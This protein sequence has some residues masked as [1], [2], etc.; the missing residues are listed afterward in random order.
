LKKEGGRPF[1]KKRR[2]F[3]VTETFQKGPSWRLMLEIVHCEPG[4]P[5]CVA[6]TMEAKILKEDLACNRGRV[7]G[8]SPSEKDISNQKKSRRSS[9]GRKKK[10]RRAFE[11]VEKRRNLLG[12]KRNGNSTESRDHQQKG[13]NPDPRRS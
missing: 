13:K 8:I 1:L 9:S 11:E 5:S 4:L 6:G 3:A 12:R 2:A 10:H 7:A